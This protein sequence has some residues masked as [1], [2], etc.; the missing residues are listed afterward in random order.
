MTHPDRRTALTL[1]AGAAAALALP[2]HAATAGTWPTR[3][4]RIVVP[5]PPGGGTDLAARI[6][7]ERLAPVLGQPV[8]VDN[9]PGASTTIGVMQVVDAEPDGHTLLF[10]GSTSYTVNPAVRPRLAYDPFRQLTP[11]A[12]LARAPVVLLTPAN[13]PYRTVQALL[14]DAE[15]RPGEVRYATFGPGSAPHLA[16]ELLASARGVRLSAVPYKGSSESTLGL[17]RGEVSLGLDTLAAAAPQIRAGKL[18]ALAVISEKR[19][20]LLPDVPGY[21]ELGLSSALFE[22]WYA[23]AGPAKLP[24][25]VREH[26][27]RALQTVMADPAVRQR[28][29]QQSLEPVLLGPPALREIMDREVVRY[30]AIAARADIRLD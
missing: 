15:R 3:A 14:A 7:A 11:V 25:P 21:G 19:S 8:V 16:T 27:L 30:R 2:A 20:P 10:S 22:G 24:E 13:G 17:L 5:F 1:L 9:K 23:L 29:E 4:I 26:L 18:R 6:V 28:M 12:L